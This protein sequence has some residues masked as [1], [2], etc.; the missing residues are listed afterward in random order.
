MTNNT[1]VLE[2]GWGLFSTG[3]YHTGGVNATFFDGSVRFISEA[4]ENGN[5]SFIVT[6]TGESPYGIWG[7]LATVNCGESVSF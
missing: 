1:V 4:I 5:P 7:A 3:S 2:L 6:H